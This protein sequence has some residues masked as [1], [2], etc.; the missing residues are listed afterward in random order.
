ML[1][2]E[3]LPIAFNDVDMCLRIGEKGYR[4]VFTPH[5][6]LYH[7]E[8]VTKTVIAAPSEIAHL[9]SRWRH[10]IAHDPYYNPNL[11]RAAE[12]CSLNME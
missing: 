5:A 11:T 7:Y 3:N 12:D 1:D 9:Q 2:A 8:S 6:V 10:V 4:I